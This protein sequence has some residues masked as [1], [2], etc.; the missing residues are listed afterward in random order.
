MSDDMLRIAISRIK[1]ACAVVLAVLLV[2]A[3]AL[4]LLIF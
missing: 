3:G 4:H 1:R 2:G